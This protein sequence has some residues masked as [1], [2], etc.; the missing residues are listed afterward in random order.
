VIDRLLAQPLLRRMAVTCALPAVRVGVE[1]RFRHSDL[2]AWVAVQL[3]RASN[4]PAA[5]RTLLEPVRPS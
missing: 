3:V 2:E 5:G 1:W 4:A